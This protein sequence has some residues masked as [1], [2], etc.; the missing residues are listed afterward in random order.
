M[1]GEL[2]WRILVAG[3][4]QGVGYR[5]ACQAVA[6]GLGLSGFV[7]NLGDG[8]VEVVASGP[9]GAVSQLA[10]WCHHGPR[11]ARVDQVRISEEPPGYQAGEGEGFRIVS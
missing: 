9:A 1:A 3:R 4:V 7:R 8:Q 2:C 6:Q 10:Q 5:L 11:A